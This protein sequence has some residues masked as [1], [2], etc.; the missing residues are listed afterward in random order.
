MDTSGEDHRIINLGTDGTNPPV[1]H[2]DMGAVSGNPKFGK[3][4]LKFDGY[5]HLS[6]PSSDDFHFGESDFTV[7]C[8][9]YFAKSTNPTLIDS[10]SEKLVAHW[11]F[12]ETVGTTASD[13]SGNNHHGTLKNQ[14]EWKKFKKSPTKY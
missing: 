7:E 9:L 1:W 5:S 12:D 2:N 8:W 11:K 3:G 14:Y 4:S 10:L 13:S 6:I